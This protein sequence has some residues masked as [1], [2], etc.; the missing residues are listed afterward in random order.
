MIGK[1]YIKIYASGGEEARGFRHQVE[2]L[3][4]VR[5]KFIKLSGQIALSFL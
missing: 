4:V 1:K 3:Q 5:S 2:G